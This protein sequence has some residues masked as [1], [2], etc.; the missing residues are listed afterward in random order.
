MKKKSINLE[1]KKVKILTLFN[2]VN[3]TITGLENFVSLSPIFKKYILVTNQSKEEAQN[4]IN[5]L[6]PK[7][8][9]KVFSLKVNS[10]KATLELFKNIKDLKIDIIHSHHAKSSLFSVIF[11]FIFNS[12]LV[13]T[14]HS[15]FNA[16]NFLQKLFFTISYLSSDLIICNSKNTKNSIPIFIDKSKLSVIYNGINLNKIKFGNLEKINNLKKSYIFGTA[17]RFVWQ[18]DLTTLIKAFHFLKSNTNV[19]VKLILIGGGPQYKQ[20]I[21]LVNRLKLSKYVQFKGIIDRNSVYEEI[22][23]FDL[24][25]VTSVY[26]GFCNALIEAAASNIPLISTSIKP[27]PEVIGGLN[28]AMFFEKRNYKELANIM[29]KYIQ[30][31]ERFKFYEKALRAKKYVSEYYSI[32]LICE[33]YSHEYLKLMSK[34][35]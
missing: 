8:N 4:I 5:S 25:I 26:E 20:I 21:K 11:K 7:N 29:I 27:L 34:N 18:K 14:V 28:N 6:Y 33:K 10:Y 35:L 17:C 3:A 24:F 22:S 23:N 16:Y 13:I 19:S 2:V 1:P 12:K 31:H 9:I 15:N 32:N 30:G